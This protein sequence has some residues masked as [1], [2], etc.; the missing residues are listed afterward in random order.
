MMTHV[1]N[2]RPTTRSGPVFEGALFASEFSLTTPDL[3]KVCGVVCF[4]GEN[5]TRLVLLPALLLSLDCAR[6]NGTLRVL[7][8]LGVD[9]VVVDAE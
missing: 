1:P 3:V 4:V 6:V 2:T 9:A 7:G 8:K 5:V